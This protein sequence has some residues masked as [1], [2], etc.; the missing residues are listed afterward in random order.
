M[1]LIVP[2]FPAPSRPSK[3]MTTRSPFSLTYCWRWQSRTCSFCSVFSYFFRFISV[4]HGVNGSRVDGASDPS[5]E[6][7]NLLDVI[8]SSCGGDEIELHGSFAGRLD[9]PELRRELRRPDTPPHVG[10]GRPQF[11]VADHRVRFQPRAAFD[12]ARIEP[13]AD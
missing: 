2:P 6:A 8:E 3:M 10:F 1:A 9:H 7:A 12:A 11:R 4:S 5:R 13:G